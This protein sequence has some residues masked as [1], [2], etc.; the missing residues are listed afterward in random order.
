MTHF[1]PRG[2]APAF[3]PGQVFA[4][5]D[6]RA[7]WFVAMSKDSG[8]GALRRGAAE[9]KRRARPRPSLARLA[10]QAARAGIE[11]AQYRCEPDGTIVVVPGKPGAA[12][13]NEWDEVLP[14]GKANEVH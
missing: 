13:F 9:T 6:A 10:K 1:L 2:A 3:T 11:V 4:G 8:R 5:A 12:S 14:D 7:F